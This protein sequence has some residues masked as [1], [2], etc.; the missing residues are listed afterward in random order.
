MKTL[1]LISLLMEDDEMFF[2]LELR[3]RQE[4]LFLNIGLQTLACALRQ[5]KER[6]GIKI[7]NEVELSSSADGMTT[8]IHIVPPGEH[9]AMSYS[10]QRVL[11]ATREGKAQGCC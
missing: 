4:C 3:T 11:M 10:H 8:Y 5:T 6:K 9:V 7:E 1:Q 2:L